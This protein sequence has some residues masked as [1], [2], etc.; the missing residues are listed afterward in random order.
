[1]HYVGFTSKRGAAEAP[2]HDLEVDAFVLGEALQV[3]WSYDP[4]RFRR[5]TVERLASAFLAE[6]AGIVARCRQALARGEIGY[7]PSDFPLAALDTALDTALDQAALDTLLGRAPGIEDLYPL[8]PLQEG[9]LFHGLYESGSELYFEQ[10]ACTLA[11]PLDVAAFARA[12][13]AVVDR[14]PALRT[15]FLQRGAGAPLQAVHRTRSHG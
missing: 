12:W 8:A 15:A 3:R 10:L 4:V 13:Q 1:M 9:M 5:A 2:R 11:G 6:L 14:H 7:T